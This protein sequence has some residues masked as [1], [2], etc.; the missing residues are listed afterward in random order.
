V[1]AGAALLLDAAGIAA[2]VPHSGAMSLLAGVRQCDAEHIVCFSHSQA[3]PANPLRVGA[4][5]PTLC[6]IEYAAQAM[7]VHGGLNALQGER[8]RAGYLA[9]LRDVRCARERLD[10]VPE[11]TIEATRLMG[12]VAS[13]IYLFKLLDAQAGTLLLSGRATV[14]L[15]I[16]KKQ[17][18]QSASSEP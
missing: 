4:M 15:D 17:V 13:V 3:D 16:D 14:I 9:A 18:N 7:A 11:M 10:G 2:R 6:G 8:P 5:L 12:E 1:S